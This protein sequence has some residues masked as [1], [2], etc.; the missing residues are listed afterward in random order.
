VFCHFVDVVFFVSD[1]AWE[2]CE[3]YLEF[4]FQCYCSYLS[5]VVRASLKSVFIV[6]YSSLVVSG[7]CLLCSVCSHLVL[8]VA[9]VLVGS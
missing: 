2:L 6:R 5:S 1:F 7:I 3:G 4:F 9:M 8:I